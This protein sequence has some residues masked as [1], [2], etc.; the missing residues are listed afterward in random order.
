MAFIGENNMMYIFNMVDFKNSL[1]KL[2]DLWLS[3]D[4]KFN[5]EAKFK[6]LS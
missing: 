6:L 3:R 5:V 4:S 1:E 2:P